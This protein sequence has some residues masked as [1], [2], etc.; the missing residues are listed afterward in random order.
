MNPIC[1]T[2]PQALK[3]YLNVLPCL[4]ELPRDVKISNKAVAMEIGVAP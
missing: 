3:D 1:Y 2:N 4:F